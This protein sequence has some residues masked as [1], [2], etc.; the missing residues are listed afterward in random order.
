MRKPFL[1]GLVTVSL[2][3]MLAVAGPAAQRPAAAAAHDLTF[4]DRVRAQEAIERVYY[5]HQIDATTPFEEAVPREVIEAKVRRS[6]KLS[7]AL[8]RLWSLPVTAE[9]LH[10][11]ALRIAAQTRMPER[12]REIQAALG[13]DAILFEETYA[14]QAIVERLA[15]DA[16]AS[17]RR[18]HAEA[19]AE[20]ERLRKQ[21]V[22]GALAPDAAHARRSVVI[23]KSTSDEARRAPVASRPEAGRADD[24]APQ[25]L[26][27]SP[28]EFRRVRAQAP[29]EVGAIG[30]VVDQRDAFTVSVVLAESDGTSEIATFEIPKLAWSGWWDGAAARFDET[31]ARQVVHAGGLL[32]AST[33]R[34]TASGTSG[35]T[36]AGSWAAN[37]GLDNFLDGRSG[38]TAVWTGTQMIVWGGYVGDGLDTRGRY[39]PTTDAWT[40]VSTAN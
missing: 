36:C 37:G 19:R 21:L 5:G 40:P 7:V 3:Q 1:S 30:A 12:L 18:L 22:S 17:D 6:L 25:T 14:R 8:E 20:A 39:D 15:R 10:G 16:F 11:E 34:S 4:E 38:H 2:C 32:P 31:E 33:D 29:A 28:D 9:M 13:D 24:A 23:L 27:L 26:E 35:P